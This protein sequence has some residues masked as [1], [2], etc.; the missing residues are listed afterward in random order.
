MGQAMDATSET[1]IPIQELVRKTTEKL[2]AN[3]SKI[4]TKIHRFPRGLRFVSKH[5][6]YIAPSFVALGPYHHGLPQLQ[7]VEEVKHA[8]AHYFC[9]QSGNSIEE[10]HGK[11]L[12]VVGEARGCYSEDA[13]SGFSH[14]EFAAMMFLDGC[15]LLRYIHDFM[16][17]ESALFS[18]R[19]VLSTGP[20]MLRDIFMLENQLPWL[21]LEVLM[22]FTDIP[23]CQFIVST[24]STFDTGWIQI[25]RLPEN[26][27]K[28]YR[29]PH[30]LGFL[31]YY[32]IGNMPPT[33]RVPSSFIR[34]FA[35]ASGAIELAEI[36]VKLT[37]SNKRWF[38][39]MS[40]QKGYLAGELSL[41]PLF[42]NDYTA[43]WLVNMAGLEAC[44]STG[45]PSDGY[46]ISSYLSLIAML[47]DKEEDVHELRAKHLVRSFFSNQEMLDL[48]KGLACH[49]RLGC[50][51]IVILEKIDEYK[52]ERHV[53]IVLHKFFY[54]N[55]KIIVAL[56][57]VAS[58]LVGIFK[59]LLSLNQN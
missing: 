53:R 35:L 32:L 39:D 56:L 1:L 13:V 21:V 30:L 37:A 16:Y 38:A 19:A 6:R 44:T 31:R 54:H 59:T 34:K 49:L 2:E 52:C 46:N 33:P 48:F 55:F 3:F 12:S 41:T 9:M 43:S 42:L 36:G 23:M 50:G 4:G 10:V 51:Y 17:A 57:S 45:W 15:F 29:P 5:D 22:T 58:V 25:T 27:L 24:A 28:R 47:M 7:E 40:V 14:S 20:C 26:E 11:I 8:A 18:N